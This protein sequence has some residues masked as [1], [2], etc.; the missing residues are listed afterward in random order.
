MGASSKKK[1]NRNP[2]VSIVTITQLK[3]FPCLEILRDIIKGQTYKNIVEWVVVEG[4][5]SE[6]DWAENALKIQGLKDDFDIPIIYIEKQPGDKLGRLRNKG[7]TACSGDITVVMDDDDYYPPERVEHAVEKLAPSHLL[8]A[9][10]SDMFIYDYTLEKFCRFIKFGENHSVNSCFAWKKKYLENHKH[11]DSKDTGEEPSFTN[12]FKEPLIQ[13]EAAKTV[14]QSS[15][16][17]NTYNKREIINAGIIKVNPSVVEV[18]IPITDMIKEPFFSRYN[19][20]FVDSKKSKYDIAYFAGGFSIKWDPTSKSLGGSEHAVVQLC[21]SWVKLGKKVVVYGNTQD[22]SQNGVDYFDWKKFPFNESFDI[23][24]LW[25]TYGMVSALPFNLKANYVWLDLHDGN[26]PKELKEMWYRYGTKI[27]KVFFKSEF[28][29]ELFERELRI[30][31]Q[32]ERYTVIP[33]GIRID[34]F[35]NNK[36]LVQRNPFRFCYCSCYTRGLLLILQNLWP[37]IIKAE[38]RA[39][40]HVYYGMD[41]VADKEFR[42]AMTLLLGSPGVMDHGRQPMDLIIREKYLSNFHLYLSKEESEIDCITIRESL[43]TGAIPLISNFGIFKEREGIHFDF[44][45]NNP[46]SYATVAVNIIEL[47]RR[48]MIQLDAI[49]GSLKESKTIVSWLDISKKWLENL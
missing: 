46:S 21:E 22:V 35:S 43:I 10:C 45:Y 28:Q 37:I 9:G 30:K 17:S 5:P 6:S 7:N 16:T 29:R 3:R 42:N 13:L 4:S 19:S 48:P 1:I 36:E 47:M 38:P 23:V 2:T 24:V 11:D 41:L 15:H 44:Q 31:I 27:N 40:L 32:P 39:E 34:E 25:R 26:Y 20:I 33:N 49:R 12:D 18:S 14:V 8:I